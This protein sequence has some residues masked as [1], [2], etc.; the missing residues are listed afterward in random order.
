ML[1]WKIE[2]YITNTKRCFTDTQWWVSKQY[3]TFLMVW[4]GMG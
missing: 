1:F 4:W 2:W 3:L